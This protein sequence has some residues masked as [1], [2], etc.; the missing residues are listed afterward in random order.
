[1][2]QALQKWH[3]TIDP[4]HQ[5]KEPDWLLEQVSWGWWQVLPLRLMPVDRMLGCPE[6]TGAWYTRRCY[7][8]CQPP[9]GAEWCCKEFQSSR[10]C[11]PHQTALCN[12][13]TTRLVVAKLRKLYLLVHHSFT[14]SEPG[15][16]CC[17][18][19]RWHRLWWE[20]LPLSKMAS[21]NAANE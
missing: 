5:K 3:L 16:H 4:T 1:M 14:W 20:T 17:Q 10:C 12:W 18:P 8:L 21:G 2:P 19:T 15:W 9:T 7:H 11:C 6:G 13:G